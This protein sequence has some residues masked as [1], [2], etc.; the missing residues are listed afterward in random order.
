MGEVSPTLQPCHT[1]CGVL[2]RKTPKRLDAVGG[3]S[4]ASPSP[5]GSAPKPPILGKNCSAIFPNHLPSPTAAFIPSNGTFIP[6]PPLARPL[7]MRPDSGRA[8]A[9]PTL[10]YPQD[11]GYPA[12]S[13]GRGIIHSPYGAFIFSIRRKERCYSVG[14]QGHRLGGFF[15][16]RGRAGGNR[17]GSKPT[18]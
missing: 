16:G 18:T 3:K 10:S 11:S 13:T 2:L 1:R 7:L 17:E 9:A 12:D 8:R 5:G 6:Y 14:G 4:Y 15:P